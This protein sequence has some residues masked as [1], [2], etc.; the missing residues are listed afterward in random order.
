[1]LNL[2]LASRR[3]RHRSVGAITGRYGGDNSRYAATHKS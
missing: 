3:R 1:M 2:A